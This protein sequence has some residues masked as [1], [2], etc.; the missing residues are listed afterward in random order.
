MLFIICYIQ[1]FKIYKNIEL[2]NGKL[3]IF[4]NKVI[5][6]GREYD[7]PIKLSELIYFDI[8]FDFFEERKNNRK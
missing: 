4:I 6:N 3:S 8:M 2:D 5:Y 1:V 7:A